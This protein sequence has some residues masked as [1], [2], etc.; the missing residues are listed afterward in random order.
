MIHIVFQ[1]ADINVLQKGFWAGWVNGRW[2]IAC[3][4]WFRSRTTSIYLWDR[5]LP[6][7]RRDRKQL[8]EF[9]PYVEQLDIVVMINLLSHNLIKRLD[10]D[11][12]PAGLG[13]GWARTSM[14]YVAI[15]GSLANWKDYQGRIFVLYL[16]N[17]PFIN[18]KGGHFTPQCCTEIQPKEF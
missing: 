16:N 18:E 8:L 10:E 17:L 15:S 5:R 11:A 12:S 9:S 2:N 7:A 1:D 14:M 3:E 6:E 4:R 13:F